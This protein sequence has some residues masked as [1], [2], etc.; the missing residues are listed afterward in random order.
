MLQIR[1]GSGATSFVPPG[2]PVVV[3][4]E[5]VERDRGVGCQNHRADLDGMMLSVVLN[6][7]KEA[8]GDDRT[9]QSVSPGQDWGGGR[10][11]FAINQLQRQPS[12]NMGMGGVSVSRL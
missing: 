10:G 2:W 6:V 3:M 4:F 9:I 11:R 12:T 1:A 8:D 5:K 7:I